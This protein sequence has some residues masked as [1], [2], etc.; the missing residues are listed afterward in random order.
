VGRA[1][2]GC[3]SGERVS[4]RGEEEASGRYSSGKNDLMGRVPEPTQLQ[5]VIQGNRGEDSKVTHALHGAEESAQEAPEFG[6]C[7]LSRARSCLVLAVCLLILR[8]LVAMGTF[9]Q[10]TIPPFSG[11]AVPSS[12]VARP[13]GTLHIKGKIA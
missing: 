4:G 11:H 3:A 2:G 12:H 7:D 5:E 10:T 9:P 8:K 6:E 13:I 1:R